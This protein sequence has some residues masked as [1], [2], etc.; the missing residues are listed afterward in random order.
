MTSVK[1]RDAA[2]VPAFFVRAIHER[3]KVFASLSRWIR[4]VGLR[5]PHTPP[6]GYRQHPH[7]P[8]HPHTHHWHSCSSPRARIPSRTPLASP[9][10]GWAAL[11]RAQPERARCLSGGDGSLILARVG[12]A[13]RG[14]AAGATIRVLK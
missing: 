3:Q 4:R 1:S 9:R 5:P 6:T 7:A 10:G 12:Y 2:S 11:A 13:V 14:T 8:A